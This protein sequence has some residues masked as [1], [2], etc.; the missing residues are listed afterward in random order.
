M[1][2]MEMFPDNYEEF[3]NQ[4]STKETKFG[5]EYIPTVKAKQAMAH[6]LKYEDSGTAIEEA[7]AENPYLVMSVCLEVMQRKMLDEMTERI[8]T[9]YEEKEKILEEKERLTKELQTKLNN[10]MKLDILYGG[11]KYG[12]AG[13]Y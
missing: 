9:L 2:C 4:Y 3:I 8:N 10:S 11:E 1:G 7:I 12:P 13:V 5:V 6:Y